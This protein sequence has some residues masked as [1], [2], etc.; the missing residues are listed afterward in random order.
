[1][2]TKILITG[3]HSTGK[4]T[5][6]EELKKLDKFRDFKFIGGV[7]RSARNLGLEI[8]ES[9]DEYTQLYCMCKDF[10]NLIENEDSKVIYDRSI[11]DTLIYSLY[12]YDKLPSW[13]IDINRSM[14]N[15]LIKK[16][17]LIVWLRPEQEI[18]DDS[19]RSMNMDFQIEV[20][21]MFDRFF[22]QNNLPVFQLKG[23]I[24]ERVDQFNKIYSHE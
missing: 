13:V 15:L 14:C 8:N 6:L 19:V 21:Y 5:L 7:T 1:M 16:F 3:T 4:S 20:D 18:D 23:S 11:L 9:G 24:Q 12:L 17:D 2:G 10:L 22:K